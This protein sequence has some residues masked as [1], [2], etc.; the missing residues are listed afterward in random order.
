MTTRFTSTIPGGDLSYT[1][2]AKPLMLLQPPPAKY[3]I[4]VRRTVKKKP[5][6]WRIVSSNGQV[7]LTSEGYA[8]KRNALRA[9]RVF[10]GNGQTNYQLDVD[11]SDL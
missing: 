8:S 3:R 1:I 10:V 5:W 7:V 11:G 2:A 9:A 4:Q 6:Y